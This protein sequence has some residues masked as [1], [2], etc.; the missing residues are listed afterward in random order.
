MHVFVKGVGVLPNK[1]DLN[2]DQY[3]ISKARYR[4]LYYFCLQYPEFLRE[5][6]ACY[7]LDG[8][9]SD[10]NVRNNAKGEPIPT[11]EPPYIR[12]MHKSDPTAYKAASAC[13]LSKDI[14]LIEQT[15][16]EA[17]GNLYQWILKAVTEGLSFGDVV[18]PCGEKEFRRT[19]RRFYYLLSFK[20]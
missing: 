9:C 14:E 3:G 10:G 2:L 4:E 20:K 11:P 8:I 18:P 6:Q 7:T 5:K 1:R 17:A 12:S 19:R 13:K 16:R 15:A